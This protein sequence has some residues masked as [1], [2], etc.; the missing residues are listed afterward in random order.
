MAETIKTS[1]NL[2]KSYVEALQEMADRSGTTMAEVLRRA[3]ANA[4]FFSDTVQKGG[5][6]L[7]DDGSDKLKQV[8]LP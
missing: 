5:K 1:V 7:I 3:I 4:K 6:V 2:P 8:I